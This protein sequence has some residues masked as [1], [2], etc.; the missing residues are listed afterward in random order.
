MGNRPMIRFLRATGL[1]CALVLSSASA[2][3]T[4]QPAPREW[5][6]YA[7]FATSDLSTFSN[8]FQPRPLEI[9]VGDTV[10]WKGGGFHNVVFGRDRVIPFG[11]TGDPNPDA[12]VPMGG[13]SFNGSGVASSGFL[14]P[15]AEFK[16]TFT[17]PGTYR[18][19]CDIH[20]NM[21]GALVVKPVSEPVALTPAAAAGAALDHFFR[22]DF[23]G[24]AIPLILKESEVTTPDGERFHELA[25]GVGD[26]H[27]EISRFLPQSIVI[28]AGDWVTWANKDPETPHTVTFLP[29]GV[30][31]DFSGPPPEGF[32]P[33]I[34]MGG[35]SYSGAEMINSGMLVNDPRFAALSAGESFSMTFTTPGTYQYLCVFHAEVGMFGTVSVLP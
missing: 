29:G 21:D 7:G 5:T 3:A 24:R 23:S 33:F 14:E 4:A 17:A 12:A 30:L 22:L 15:G 1:A 11:P 28:R 35:N 6:A 10:T 9:N 25:A 34:P 20:Q 27:L 26:G 32:S 16:L 13:P 8:D 19:V 2:I 31:P 18:Y